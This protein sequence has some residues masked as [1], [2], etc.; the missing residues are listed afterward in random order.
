MIRIVDSYKANEIFTMILTKSIDYN[1][2]IEY[3][4]KGN[5]LK[6][7]GIK[8]SLH[9]ENVQLLFRNLENL[10]HILEDNIIKGEPNV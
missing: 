5:Y 10:R 8:Y 7:E 2:A 3:S 9:C 6:I 4:L 1:Q